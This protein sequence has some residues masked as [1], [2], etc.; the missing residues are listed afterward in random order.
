MVFG[1]RDG[2][3]LYNIERR[4]IEQR[5]ADG[6]ADMLTLAFDKYCAPELVAGS[7]GYSSL[8]LSNGLMAIARRAGR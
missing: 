7:A 1:V 6:I 3:Q 2:K 8:T 5:S 4:D